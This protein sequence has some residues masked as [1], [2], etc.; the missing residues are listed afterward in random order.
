MRRGLIGE[1]LGHSYSKR[2]HEALGGYAY[3]LIEVSPQQLDALMKAKEFAAL[4]VT[5]PYKQTVIPYLDELDER[6]QRIGAVNTV[7]NN[8]GRLIGKNTDYYGCRFMLE[9]AGIEI[10]DKKVILL[11]NGGAA[12][13][14][15]AVLED[16]GAS[17]ILKVKRN[18]SAQTLTYEEAYRQHSDTQVIVNTSPVGMFPDQE[19]NP[20]ELNHFSQLESVADVIYNPH[21]TRL[22][23]EAQK[24]GCKT[25]TGLSMLTA[26]AAEAIRAFTGKAVSSEAILKMT[27]DL[28]REKMNLVLI[29]M[30][31]CGKSTVGALLA[32]ALHM[33]FVDTDIVLQEQQGKKLQTIID[34]V[35]NDAFL[36]IEEDCI[37]GLEYNN[38]VIATGGSVVYGKKAMRHLHENGLVVYIRLPY[39]EIE[40]RLSN[41]ATRGVTLKKG[42]TLHSLYDERIPLYEAEA[43]YVFDAE[44]GDVEK[45]VL[46]LADQ[47]SDRLEANDER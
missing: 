37:C 22:I 21:R 8:H 41:L 25:A 45:T 4:N 19:G 9:Q 46:D 14:V 36:K 16:L 11:G 33:D 5:I 43:D 44:K 17:S 31:G 15:Y 12:Q 40:R 30:P 18:P 2:I 13:A 28:A 23:V 39:E 7:V 20:I 27:A 34:A 1:H 29:G 24:R 42:Q 38:T 32:A 35:G 26:Q 6:A 10:R 47:L 3:E